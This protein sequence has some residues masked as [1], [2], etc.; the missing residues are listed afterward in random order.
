[1]VAEAN[2]VMRARSA[3]SLPRREELG[4]VLLQ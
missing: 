2:D 3:V 1:M 4:V